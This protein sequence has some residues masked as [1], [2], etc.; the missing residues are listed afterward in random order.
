MES[1]RGGLGWGHILEDVA[2]RPV[3]HPT[4]GPVRFPS[5]SWCQGRYD[6]GAPPPHHPDLALDTQGAGRTVMLSFSAFS[7]TEEAEMQQQEE[8][9]TFFPHGLGSLRSRGWAVG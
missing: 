1:C 4:P 6:S 3:P 8:H 9:G 7:D 5:G 2:S